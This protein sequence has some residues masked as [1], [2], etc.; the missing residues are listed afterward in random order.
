MTLKEKIIKTFIKLKQNLSYSFLALIFKCYSAK[1]CQR[2]FYNTVKML[3]ICL[4][5]AIPWPLREEIRRNIPECF[6]SFEDVRV[7]LD[8]TEVFIQR[9]AELCC[10][11][12]T[13][14]YYKSAQTCKIV[15]GVSPAGNITFVSKSYG[16]Q[17][18]DSSI[19]QQSDLIHL[20]EPGDAI[21]VDRGFLIDEVCQIN[22]WKCVRPPFLKD[23]NQFSKEESILTAKIAKARVHVE[24]SNQCIK[25]FKILGSV[26]PVALVP[27]LEDIFIIIFA[28]INMSS[29]ILSDSKFMK[30]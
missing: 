29:P 27:I 23:K 6:E 25:T 7:V 9:P 10:Q 17:A 11:I 21:M 5:A 13:Y 3:S 28:T 1:H 19:F 4:K 26:M 20:L 30:M 12:L 8:C 14:S 15:T 24:R 2:I 16:G 22:R 18:T